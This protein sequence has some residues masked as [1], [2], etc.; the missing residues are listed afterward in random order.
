MG[1]MIMSQAVQD[2]HHTLGPKG[3]PQVSVAN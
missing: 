1:P 2:E 3:F